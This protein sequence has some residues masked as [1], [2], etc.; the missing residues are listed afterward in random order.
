MNPASLFNK[1]KYFGGS[2]ESELDPY[3]SKIL[4]IDDDQINVDVLEEIMLEAG[5]TAITTTTDP[6]QAIELYK[7]NTFDLILLDILMPVLDGFAVIEAFKKAKKE[8]DT[9]ILVLSALS[10]QETRLRALSNGAR[11]YLSKPF[12]PAEVLV[13]IRNLLEVKL[14]QI[15]LRMHNEILD[16]E[17]QKRTKEIRETRLE[18]IN[19]LGTAAEY[20]DNETGL[21]IIRMS[22][23]SHEIAKAAGLKSYDSELIFNASPMHDIGKIGIPDTIL[24][25]A[26]KLTEDEWEIMKTHTTIGAKILKGHDSDLLQAALSIAMTH[27]E[28]WDGTG[29]PLGLSR[30]DIPLHGR[31]VAIADVFDALTSV[32]PYKEAWPVSKAVEVMERDTGTHFDPMLIKTFKAC[33]PKIL[34]IKNKYGDQSSS[35]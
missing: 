12:N 2:T 5:Y 7:T 15:Q 32:R 31:I 16:K 27:H 34:D 33:L 9:P 30:Q 4:I 19:R 29:Y 14:A 23:Y 3:A 13:R 20:R 26:G 28:K 11:D 21:H 18:I 6:E 24:L 1:A 35:N 10:D 17:V 25:K 8:F 22:Q